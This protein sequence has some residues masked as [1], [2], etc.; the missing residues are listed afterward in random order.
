MQKLEDPE[1]RKRL[2]KYQMT[3]DYAR[4]YG[5]VLSASNVVS[6]LN[7]FPSAS[8]VV[9]AS[10]W[11]K[12]FNRTIMAG[13]QPILVK[14]PI[15]SNNLNLDLDNAARI[16]GYNSYEDAQTKSKNSTQVLSNIRMT[17]LNNRAKNFYCYEKKYVLNNFFV[18]EKI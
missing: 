5:H 10:T 18:L 1:V 4:Q 12:S 9:E 3:N 13:A 8:F 17:A 16:C 14:K 2:L 6:I 15:P 7:Q 11:K